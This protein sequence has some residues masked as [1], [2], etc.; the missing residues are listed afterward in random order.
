MYCVNTGK[1]LKGSKK[2]TYDDCRVE[3]SDSDEEVYLYR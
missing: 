3:D 1:D 2:I